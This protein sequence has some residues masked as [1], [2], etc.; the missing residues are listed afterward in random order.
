MTTNSRRHEVPKIISIVNTIL[1]CNSSF[2][3]ATLQAI[4]LLIACNINMTRD[5]EMALHK[6]HKTRI[7]TKSILI[8]GGFALNLDGTKLTTACNNQHVGYKARSNEIESLRLL[9]YHSL[10]DI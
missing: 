8:F 3:Q 9:E 2:L 10:V 4:Q 7:E 5:S 6:A 1:N